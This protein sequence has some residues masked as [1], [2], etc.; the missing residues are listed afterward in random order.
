[1]ILQRKTEV[2]QLERRIASLR[3]W[4]ESSYEKVDT[5]LSCE[6][7]LVLC[8]GLIPEGRV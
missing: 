6:F 5:H 4:V 1:M 8:W 3:R 2:G 7:P